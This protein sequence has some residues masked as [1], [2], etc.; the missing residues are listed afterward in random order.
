MKKLLIRACAPLRSGTVG[1]VA[2]IA[3]GLTLVSLCAASP[4]SAQDS[5]SRLIQ[6]RG[7]VNSISKN[8]PKSAIRATNA[9][10]QCVAQRDA[11]RIRGALDLPF[12]SA[13]Q[14]RIL[15][16][17][18]D[19]YDECLGSSPDFDTLALPRVLFA[20]AAAE[21]FVTVNRRKI[22]LSTLV[23]MT[24]EALA[25]ADFKPRTSL[26][27]VG[28]CVVRRNPANALA[29]I[30]TRPT[31]AE[32]IAAVQVLVPD[33]GPC[34]DTGQEVTMNVPNLRAI[35]AYAIYRAASKLGDIGG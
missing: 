24:D 15:H 9:F 12:A 31:T 10:G 23:G 28:L 27:D 2:S 25:K 21:W 26:E 8:D 7:A 3:T 29:L 34:V 17:S 18:L 6:N 11:K 4:A 33:V 1:T 35:I 22:D 19:T 14:V 20:G 16:K 13:E 30:A 5:S 32:E